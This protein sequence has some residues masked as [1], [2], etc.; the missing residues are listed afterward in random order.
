MT[1]F[2]LKTNV[3]IH[4]AADQNIRLLY[5]YIGYRGRSS[6]LFLKKRI[7][8]R[9]VYFFLQNKLDLSHLIIR[10]IPHWIHL[11]FQN[12][13]PRENTYLMIDH[14]HYSLFRLPEGG[15]KSA[16][17]N[18]IPPFIVT[19][20]MTWKIM[21]CLHVKY[22]LCV[23]L[24]KRNCWNDTNCKKKNKPYLN[25]KNWITVEWNGLTDTTHVVYQ[26]IEPLHTLSNY[27]MFS[28]ILY[29][30]PYFEAVYCSICGRRREAVARYR[31]I[32][33][34]H[35]NKLILC[36]KDVA[37]RLYQSYCE[38]ESEDTKSLKF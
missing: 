13:I 4:Y 20:S 21:R 38:L 22:P 14:T 3:G 27:M 35:G 30:P 9:P 6:I 29:P 8:S 12:V 18:P 15:I 10:M 37:L 23:L 16:D 34:V 11:R 2:P 5:V 17:M 7:F 28:L 36:N 32:C 1:Y 33:L 19:I 26:I 31:M 24:Y 25:V